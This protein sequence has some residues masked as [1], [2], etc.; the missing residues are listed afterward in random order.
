[1]KSFFLVILQM[2]RHHYGAVWNMDVSNRS[3]CPNLKPVSKRLRAQMESVPVQVHYKKFTVEHNSLVDFWN[4]WYKEYIEND[5]PKLIVRF[6]DVI[7]YPKQITKVICEC[8][9]GRLIHPDNKFVYI[10]DSAKKGAAHGKDNE[11]TSYVDALVKYGTEKGRY[12]GYYDEDLTYANEQ[13]DPYLMNLFGYR[14]AS[15]NEISSSDSGAV[16]TDK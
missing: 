12:T 11:K 16:V 7:F 1:M 5:F 10:T 8:A 2:C 4:D 14:S 15:S 9:G 6:E 13:L 3:H